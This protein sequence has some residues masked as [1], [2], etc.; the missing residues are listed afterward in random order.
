MTDPARHDDA[1]ARA[2]LDRRDLGETRIGPR[3][4]A[5]GERTYLM[6]IL[7][8]T[9]DSFSGDG[10][11][12]DTAAGDPVDVAVAT[13]RAMVAAGAD[14]LDVG[15]ESTRPGHRDVP[16]EEERA[17]VVPIVAALREAGPDG[18]EIIAAGGSKPEGGD[19]HLVEGHWTGD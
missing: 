17:R 1:T 7:N 2:P 16:V 11:L 12:S 5:W 15:G 19:G 10:L 9:P 8:A 13:G 6:G 18:L 4:F 14:I 3:T